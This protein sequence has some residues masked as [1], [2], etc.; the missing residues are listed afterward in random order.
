M[1][2]KKMP[3]ITVHEFPVAI[4]A[5]SQRMDELRGAVCEKMGHDKQGNGADL[6]VLR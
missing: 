6:R 3:Q 4:I 5:A 2:K 1:Q